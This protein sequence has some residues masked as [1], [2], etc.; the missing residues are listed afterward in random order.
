[1]LVLHR[2]LE[3][4]LVPEVV[5]APQKVSQEEVGVWSA[6]QDKG[7]FGF[8]GFGV[9][10]FGFDGSAAVGFGKGLFGDGE[11]GFG[12]D[13]IRWVS[14][15][16]GTGEY[17]FAVKVRDAVGNEADGIESDDVVVIGQA[18][19]VEAIKVDSYDKS[20]DELVMRVAVG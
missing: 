18:G 1:M 5:V 14:G 6:W 12:C 9:S 17:R 4:V 13:E 15:V 10:D 3:V 8:C 16:P 20:E 2:P 19:G 7:G 11:F